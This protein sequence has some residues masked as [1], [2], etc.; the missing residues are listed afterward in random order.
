MWFVAM[1]LLWLL[2]PAS[3]VDARLL[4]L[5]GEATLEFRLINVS[6]S[7][8]G[9]DSQ[10]IDWR[11]LVTAGSNGV[12]FREALGLYQLNFTFINDDRYG[13]LKSN[14]QNYNYFGSLT[15]FTR[16]M[17]LSLSAQRTTQEMESN[18]TSAYVL[19]G[20]VTISIYNLVWDLPHIWKLPQLHLNLY[21][22]TVETNSCTALAPP[23]CDN[24]SRTFGGSLT[25]TDQYPYRYIIKNTVLTWNLS[26]SGVQE[27]NGQNSDV[28][29]GGR[30]TADSQWTPEIKSNV[31]ASY[32]TNVSSQTPTV[33]GLTANV[34][35]LG[36]SV[37]YRPGLKLNSNINYDFTRDTNDRHVGGIDIFY[38]P[39]PQFDV[40]VISRGTF[41]ELDHSEI[42]GGY[43][44][45]LVLYRPILNLNAS[46]SGTAGVTTTTT[47]AT[48]SQPHTK[49][50][51]LYQNYAASASYFKLY[52]LF[53]INVSG[54]VALNNTISSGANQTN[55]NTNWLAQATNTKT[56]FVTIT[57]SYSGYVNEQ[58][59][60]G[61]VNQ[62]LN[63]VR[64]DATSSYFRE[65]LLR[66]DVLT[67]HLGAGDTLISGESDNGQTI[68]AG[69][70]FLYGWRGV[71]LGGGY[72]GH[73]STQPGEDYNALF[74]SLNWTVPPLLQDLQIIINGRFEDRLM[75]DQSRPDVTTGTVNINGTYQIGLVQFNLQYALNYYDELAYTLSHN[76]YFRVTRRFSL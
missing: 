76:I 59:S 33:P 49:G 30:M 53:R 39:T 27:F 14:S 25:A 45:V 66:G 71:G 26:F 44:S 31:R 74:T 73:F 48:A 58:F 29:V 56:Q 37:F 7:G 13:D 52:E 36:F 16:L 63:M 38:R 10:Y 46:F 6:G 43:G 40:T 47:D 75:T 51:S 5:T 65:L 60:G 35:A 3:R 1:G 18:T 68:D 55:L 24:T 17:P 4:D 61:G 54:G 70:D 57:G 62:T 2:W 12:L 32:T 15:F 28:S 67:L 34:T 22:S 21:Y 72:L 8:S 41:L 42:L 9:G 64:G 69:V 23:S 19:S 50:T 11:E 20:K